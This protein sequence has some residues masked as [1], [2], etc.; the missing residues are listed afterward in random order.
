MSMWWRHWSR[1]WR[2]VLRLFL[3]PFLQIE[4]V[5]TFKS[6]TSF[7]GALRRQS[8][9]T[10]QNQDVTNVSSPSHMSLCNALSSPTSTAAAP[11]GRE[12]HS[13]LG[14][15]QGCPWKWSGPITTTSTELLIKMR[16]QVYEYILKKPRYLEQWQHWVRCYK[17]YGPL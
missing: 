6:G 17:T 8:S 16:K 7:Q 12:W 2:A 4:V 1:L 10:S 9:T 11:S 15:C 14:V 13:S 3:S 5:N